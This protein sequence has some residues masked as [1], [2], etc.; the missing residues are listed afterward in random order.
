MTSQELY[1][2]CEEL[3]KKVDWTNRESIHEYNQAVRELHKQRDREAREEEE[4]AE[5][6]ARG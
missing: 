4:R 2:K 3:F 1:R 5:R 6:A